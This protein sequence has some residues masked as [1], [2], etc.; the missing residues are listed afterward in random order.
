MMERAAALDAADP[1]AAYRDRFVPAP[2]V[3]YL[4]GN[5]LG[6][7]LLATR[8]NLV[9]FVDQDWGDRLIRAWDEGWTETPTTLGDTIGRVALGAAPG[10]TVVG[11]STTVMLYKVARA[12][13]DARPART[14]IV[15]DTEN[16]PTDRYVLEGI[17]AERG[18]TLRWIDADPATGVTASQ[19]AGVVGPETA[20]VLL[21]HVAYRSGYLA[22]VPAITAVAH[23]AGALVIWDLCHSV[24]VVPMEV[25]AWGVDI[26]VGCTYKYLN[27]GPGA[28]AFAYVTTALQETARQPIQGWM[29][30]A[31]PFA[32]GPRYE[33]APGIRQF[34]SGTPPVLG[35]LPMRDMLNLIDEA[36]LDA[37]RAKS[38]ALTEFVLEL[39]DELLVPLGVRVSTPRDAALRGG[40]VTLDHPAF[41]EI[42]PLL[43]KRGVL[44]DFRPPHGMRVGLSPLST[45]FTEVA[46]GLQIVGDELGQQ[47]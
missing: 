27:G 8:D 30:S 5:S 26:A 9:R 15:L 44:P 19:V 2:V 13:L 37:I 34:V 22:D 41:R 18:A 46:E 14:E 40:H 35:M 12:A 11:D 33:P 17:A 36:G 28:P 3:A 42:V 39:A 43:W 45:S 29:G 7:P 4:D 21:S 32:M 31:D 6:R 47:Q 25:D 1:L 38:V 24:G 20:I 23:D 16:F 10:Q